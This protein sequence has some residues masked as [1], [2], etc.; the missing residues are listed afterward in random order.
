MT[1]HSIF[2]GV[3]QLFMAKA[4]EISGSFLSSEEAWADSDEAVVAV[5]EAL[6]K[7]ILIGDYNI[8]SNNYLTVVSNEIFA[9]NVFGWLSSIPSVWDV[10]LAAETD[11]VEFQFNVEGDNVIRGRAIGPSPD[12]PAPL[13]GYYN[14]ANNTIAFTIG[15]GSDNSRYYWIN[16]SGLMALTWEIYGLNS[17]YYDAPHVTALEYCSQINGKTLEEDLGFE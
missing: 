1:N 3:S 4:G 2:A 14:S 7:V 10:C 16:L 12:Y 13:V 15:L 6:G 5:S 11:A 9:K 8:F 17:N